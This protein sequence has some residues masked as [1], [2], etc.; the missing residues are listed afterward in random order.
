MTFR[1][2]GGNGPATYVA[3]CLEIGKEVETARGINHQEMQ[4]ASWDMKKYAGRKAFI[5]IVDQS[6]NGWGHVTADHFQFDGKLLKHYSKTPFTRHDHEKSSLTLVACSFCL[7]WQRQ[8]QRRLHFGRRHEP[9]HL[10]RLRG[11]GMQD[12]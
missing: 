7:S 5:K 8:P 10:G 3:L 4:K 9:G 1:V 6:T 12:T 11:Q 2:G